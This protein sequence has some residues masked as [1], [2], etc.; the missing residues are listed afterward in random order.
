MMLAMKLGELAER[1]GAE[2]RNGDPSTEVLGDAWERSYGDLAWTHTIP[3]RVLP[4]Y[5]PTLTNPDSPAPTITMAIYHIG[6]KPEGEITIR[7][8]IC[9]SIHLP[10]TS[11]MQS[12]IADTALPD[13]HT[14]QSCSSS[15]PASRLSR[16]PR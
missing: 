6:K 9:Q 11:P 3:D 16:S 4:W 12:T 8:S 13:C 7:P 5:L 2:L 1:L 10:A 14:K 15:S